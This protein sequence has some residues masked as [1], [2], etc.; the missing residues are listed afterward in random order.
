MPRHDPEDA[1]LQR[2]R[3]GDTA[4]VAELATMFGSRIFQIAFSR[5]RNR[6]DAEEVT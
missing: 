3:R 1:L 6:E 2:L 5:L 4:A